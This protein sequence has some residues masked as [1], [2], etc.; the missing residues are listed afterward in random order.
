MNPSGGLSSWNSGF[1]QL[2]DLAVALHARSE[3]DLETVSAASK[4]CS[5]CWSVVDTWREVEECRTCMREIAV[6]LKGILDENG[7]TYRGGHICTP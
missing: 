2:V 1:N 3:L 6:K 7:R 5:E 4:A